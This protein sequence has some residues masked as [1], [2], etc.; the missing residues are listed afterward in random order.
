MLTF[1]QRCILC[2][3][4]NTINWKKHQ[5]AYSLHRKYKKPWTPE[6]SK[7][8]SKTT[9]NTTQM[10]AKNVKIDV[11]VDIKVEAYQVDTFDGRNIKGKPLVHLKSQILY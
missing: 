8:Q 4:E 3:G 5:S 11:E 2:T 1:G 6:R 9:L 7:E 10:K